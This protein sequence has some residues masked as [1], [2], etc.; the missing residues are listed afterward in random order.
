MV[1]MVTMRTFKIITDKFNV[2]IICTSAHYSQKRVEICILI[3]LKFLLAV[4]YQ[5]KEITYKFFS[6]VILLI[7]APLR[8]DLVLLLDTAGCQVEYGQ[9]HSRLHTASCTRSQNNC[10]FSVHRIY[11]HATQVYNVYCESGLKHSLI[12]SCLQGALA[13][14]RLNQISF[15]SFFLYFCIHFLPY[16]FPFFFPSFLVLFPFSFFFYLPFCISSF[17]M[18]IIFNLHLCLF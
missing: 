16:L 9:M 8:L 7:T 10:I 3:I 15:L 11:R 4:P 18:Y 5:T 13:A 2:V 6:G 17:L 12:A 1:R 14:Q